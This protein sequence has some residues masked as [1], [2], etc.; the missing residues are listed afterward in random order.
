ML[1]FI[2]KFIFQ[3]DKIYL[4]K[5]VDTDLHKRIF[6]V[7]LLE[8]VLDIFDHDPYHSNDGNDE[9]SKCESA[10]MVSTNSEKHFVYKAIYE[11]VPRSKNKKLIQSNSILSCI[12]LLTFRSQ[13]KEV[14]LECPPYQMSNTKKQTLL[15][16]P[17]LPLQRRRKTS[18]KARKRY[19][20]KRLCFN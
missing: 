11:N 20:P 18:I 10:K 14:T 5:K 19:R 8:F 13:T 16:V 4:H 9:G 1:I 2:I 6:L 17:S 7:I 12:I 15:Q 3:D